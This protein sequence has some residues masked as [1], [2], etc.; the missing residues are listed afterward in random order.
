MKGHG[1]RSLPAGRS[2]RF[3]FPCLPSFPWTIFR[4][5]HA[6]AKGKS[7][8]RLFGGFRFSGADSL[9]AA[10]ALG[11]LMGTERNGTVIAAN[12]RGKSI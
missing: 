1:C 2:S 6:S 5:P 11:R 8:S 3:P 7:D 10:R 4:S 12:H 9:K